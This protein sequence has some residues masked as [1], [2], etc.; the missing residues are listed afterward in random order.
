MVEDKGK[1]ADR[2]KEASSVCPGRKVPFFPQ[3]LRTG[4][5]LAAAWV[6]LLAPAALASGGLASA[7]SPSP[8]LASLAP[9]SPAP[10]G[11]RHS[12]ESAL[13]ARE[14]DPAVEP[15]VLDD[16]QRA[17]VARLIDE[18]SDLDAAELDATAQQKV[19]AA[20]AD[21]VL[22]VLLRAGRPTPPGLSTARRAQ[23]AERSDEALTWLRVA[24][25]N[26]TRAALVSDAVSSA[27]DVAS[28]APELSVAAMRV[29]A[30]LDLV[31]HSTEVAQ[32][33]DTESV[34]AATSIETERLRVSARA[35]L[36]QI[37]GR[38]FKDMEAFRSQWDLLRGRS[39]EATGR[40]E[41][42]NAIGIANS[43]ALKLIEY[44]P[45]RLG[46][47]PMEWPSAQMRAEAARAVGRAV[48]A[49]TMLP[50]QAR[51]ALVNGLDEERSED[52]LAARLQTLLDLLQG[53]DPSGEAA[54]QL[55]TLVFDL[56]GL[57]KARSCEEIWV[58]I[59]ALTRLGHPYGIEGDEMRGATVGL[60]VQLFECALNRGEVR[61]LDPDA[62]QGAMTSLSGVVRSIQDDAYATEV[63]RPFSKLVRPM[64]VGKSG[65]MRR[66]A[67]P[68]R[69]R[70]AAADAFALSVEASDAEDLVAL[71]SSM[72]TPE[73]EYELL[74]ALRAVIGVLEP[75][76]EEAE[77]VIHELFDTVADSK[78]DSRNRALELLLSE[79]VKQALLAAE[80]TKEARWVEARLLAEPAAEL[81][82]RLAS[83]LG[84]LGDG[85]SL[86]RLLTPEPGG[87]P[88]SAPLVKLAVANEELT[89]AAADLARSL[90]ADHPSRRIR[91]ALGIA[92]SQ[93]LRADP[94][95]SAESL[96]SQAR[97][98]IRFRAALDL[99]LAVDFAQSNDAEAGP[100]MGDAERAA[101]LGWIFP[102][103]LELRLAQ[104]TQMAALF[105]GSD[106]AA[107]AL[108]GLVAQPLGASPSGAKPSA[109]DFVEALMSSDQMRSAASLGLLPSSEE[110][111]ERELGRVMKVFRDVLDLVHT[112]GPF[113]GWTRTDLLREG[114]DL[115]LELGKRD[116]AVRRLGVL[117][118]PVVPAQGTG[119]EAG[120]EAT[121]VTPPASPENI[122][123]YASL[124]LEADPFTGES[125]IRASRA[126]FHL[127]EL[128]QR[129][130]WT[131]EPAD[132]RLLDLKMALQVESMMR[133]QDSFGPLLRAAIVEAASSPQVRADL[134]A[135]DPEGA[136]A[137]WRQLDAKD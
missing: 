51:L 135:V 52:A 27:L 36:F 90:S 59:G 123:L 117:L 4:S 19:G 95:G 100:S 56:A 54:T 65:A 105:S 107:L 125:E 17:R 129:P 43:H 62:L 26:P 119:G 34:P 109:Q 24:L 85:E 64:V 22:A 115:L 80:R 111:Q 41:L 121:P 76:T 89:V 132:A 68:L 92:G 55:R 103:A 84:L 91:A 97:R 28:P 87:G 58:M 66:A 10:T 63:A 122:R 114:A 30:Q 5:F 14:P 120:S 37:Y 113:H 74:G 39:P 42:L 29:V 102:A 136:E 130:S 133:P 75:G 82:V 78:F 6:A 134:D 112:D 7:A 3:T 96:A 88:S 21:L 44:A 128:I 72:D 101:A 70:R 20:G 127:T 50:D 61:A 108:R 81:Q 67:I 104:P 13:D 32:W 116:A 48:A 60:A 69:V 126:A 35:A 57:A 94:V 18:I 40:D 16:A 53:A 83:L 110:V 106:E 86:D 2:C 131:N 11:E 73:L 137:I 93:S 8:A 77:A 47:G 124:I 46:H 45:E 1:C 98:P 9:A 118:D 15:F 31:E 49:G 23:R 99:M 71:V 12:F 38:W 25:A 33:L 79:D